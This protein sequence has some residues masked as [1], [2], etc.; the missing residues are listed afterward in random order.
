VA[1]EQ[2]GEVGKRHA[3]EQKHLHEQVQRSSHGMRHQCGGKMKGDRSWP[4][5]KKCP[6]SCEPVCFHH[7][8]DRPIGSSS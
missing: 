4:S 5:H 7:D 2:C 1:R 3:G 8:G 6:H